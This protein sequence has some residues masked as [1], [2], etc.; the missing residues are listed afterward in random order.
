MIEK[1]LRCTVCFWR[2]PWSEAERAPRVRPSDIPPPMQDLQE[3]ERVVAIEAG[4]YFV[5]GDF[6]DGFLRVG[7]EG[8]E[9][10]G[11]VHQGVC[12]YALKLKLPPRLATLMG[13]LTVCWI[14]P[15]PASGF[16]AIPWT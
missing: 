8:E 7:D 10:G 9:A 15:G 1:N 4:F 3:G 12:Q 6:A 2:G 14:V 5:G 11:V 16:M 13:T